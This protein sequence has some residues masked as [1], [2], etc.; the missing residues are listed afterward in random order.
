MVQ[1][2]MEFAEILRRRRMIR[3]FTD[4][5]VDQQ[6]TERILNA[7]LRAPSAGYSQGYALIVLESPEDRDRLWATHTPSDSTAGWAPEVL[8]GIKRAPLLVVV[9]TS[10]DAYLD[11]YAQSDKGWT[12]RDEARWPVP[13]WYVD[14]GCVALLLLLAS[15]DE[16]LGALLFGIVPDDLPAFRSTFGI[17]ANYDVVG[18]VAIGHPDPAVPPRDLRSRKRSASE[19][20]HRGGW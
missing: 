15:V 16:G 8:A 19:L 12:D 20:V 3:H 5:P 2:A 18:C 4:E 10:K 9:L 6:A 13:Y 14:A 17:P 1:E 7:A 11:R